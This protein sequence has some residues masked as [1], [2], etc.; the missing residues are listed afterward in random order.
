MIG[1]PPEVSPEA[2]QRCREP[3][4]SKLIGADIVIDVVIGIEESRCRS[5]RYVRPDQR[6]RSDGQ[7]DIVDNRDAERALGGV[8]VVVRHREGHAAQQRA[9][10]AVVARLAVQRRVL[11]RLRQRRRIGVASPPGRGIGQA[12]PGDVDAD[13]FRGPVTADQV[14]SCRLQR[15]HNRICRMRR[16][17]RVQRRVSTSSIDVSRS[18]GTSLPNVTFAIPDAS[19]RLSVESVSFEAGGTWSRLRV[20][21]NPSSSTVRLVADTRLGTES[22]AT[23]T[24][25]VEDEVSPSW[26]VMVV[27]DRS[28]RKTRRRRK[29]D[30]AVRQEPD[31]PRASRRQR[32][33]RQRR[34]RIGAEGRW[35]RQH[36]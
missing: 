10:L 7:R 13:H 20:A 32:R 15:K 3:H 11:D 19:V 8:G 34:R 31:R 30:V 14:A 4:R 21:V 9:V 36:W 24:V 6:V 33:R 12:R 22:A 25:S 17:L 28:A 16:Q 5:P 27:D 18:A 2:V 26:S 35:C 1:T 29:G 23:V